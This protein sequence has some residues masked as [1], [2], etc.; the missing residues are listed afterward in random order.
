[1]KFE[2]ITDWE[3]I[4]SDKFQK[5]WFKW[6]DTS[7]SP[8]IFFHPKMLKAWVSTYINL[9]DIQ[10]LFCIAVKEEGMVFLPLVLWKKN[11]K[12]AF[13]NVIIPAGYSDFDYHDPILIGNLDLNIFWDLLLKEIDEKFSFDC[14]ITDDIIQTINSPIINIFKEQE[15]PFIELNKFDTF[16][17]YLMSLSKSTRKE[18]RKS[19]NSLEKLG[20]LEYQV[21]GKTEALHTLDEMLLQ[22][23]KRYPNAYKAVDFHKNLINTLSDSNLIHFSI[24]SLNKKVISWRIGFIYKKIYYSYMPVFDNHFSKYSVSKLHILFV[25]ENLFDENYLIYDLMRGAKN[26]KKSFSTNSKS[27]QSYEFINFKLSS[28]IKRKL[29]DLKCLI[30]K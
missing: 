13:E 1:M 20:L 8:N 7:D 2:W 28:Q 12:N 25:V 17:D 19:K 16:D 5:Q 6:M 26:Y 4:W 22:H 3:T 23:S 10:P 21:Y 14:F 18:Y 29:I 30:R 11:W 9:R 27:V 15:C 24:I